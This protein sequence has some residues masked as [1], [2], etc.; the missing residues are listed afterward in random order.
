MGITPVF[1][2]LLLGASGYSPPCLI[3]VGDEGIVFFPFFFV[4]WST[5]KVEILRLHF[6]I[7]IW[8]LKIHE[9]NNKIKLCLLN[10]QGSDIFINLLVAQYTSTITVYQRTPDIAISEASECWE[11]NH[12]RSVFLQVSLAFCELP[13]NVCISYF[14][15][16]LVYISDYSKYSG[17]S[18]NCYGGQKC[19]A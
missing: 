1:L 11:G 14:A 2:P 5:W 15:D 7:L 19:S 4:W 12:T 6:Q 16:I 9:K 17:N 13:V 8:D 3:G 18:W 10:I